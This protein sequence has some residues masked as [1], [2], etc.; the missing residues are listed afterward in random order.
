M[1]AVSFG[2]AEISTRSSPVVPCDHPK[3]EAQKQTA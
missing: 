3:S 1:L 2:G